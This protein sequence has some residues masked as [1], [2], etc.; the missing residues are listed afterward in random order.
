MTSA[1]PA[2]NPFEPPKVDVFESGPANEN[3]AVRK[4][5]IKH[6]ASLQGVGFLW[7]IGGLF[8]GLFAAVMV[9]GGP[10]TPTSRL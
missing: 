7:V 3:E 10:G 2:P 8:G 4:A 1:P 9:A 5:H 6:E